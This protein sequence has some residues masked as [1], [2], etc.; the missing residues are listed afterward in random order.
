M[1]LSYFFELFFYNLRW[2][3]ASPAT[4]VRVESPTTWGNCGD[5]NSI[6]RREGIVCVGGHG[7]AVEVWKE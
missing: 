4:L 2:E 5:R 1:K 3:W 7:A 6:R